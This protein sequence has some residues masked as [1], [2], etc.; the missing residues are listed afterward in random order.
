[1][2]LIPFVGNLTDKIGRRPCMIVGA[3]GSGV[4]GYLYLY[5]VD[6]SNTALA[7]VAAMLMWGVVYQGYN[8]TF[9]AFY[10]E[11]FPTRTRVTAFAVSQNLGTMATAFL[12]AIFATVAP[13][14]SNVPLIVGSIV[15]ALSIVAAIAAYTARE[16]Y[17][18]HMNDLGVP[19]TKPVPREEYDRIRAGS[20]SS[21]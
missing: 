19:G 3:L 6:T 14:G 17:R 5:A 10:Q 8:A 2:V 1:V 4:M 13:P 9:P 7:F 16:T 12:P 18:L 21:R 11:L 15:L 20:M